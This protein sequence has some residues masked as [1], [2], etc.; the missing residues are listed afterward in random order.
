[1][2]LPPHPSTAMLAL[3]AIVL[4]IGEDSFTVYANPRDVLDVALR[5]RRAGARWITIYLPGVG[6]AG[7][8]QWRKPARVV[9][10]ASTATV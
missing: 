4:T 10:R 2:S 9:R 5:L 6:V 8:W 3:P 1:M 7:A